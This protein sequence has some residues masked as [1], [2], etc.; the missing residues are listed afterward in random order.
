MFLFF[1]MKRTIILVLYILII[2][3]CALIGS[4]KPSRTAIRELFEANQLIVNPYYIPQDRQV[5]Q[6]CNLFSCEYDKPPQPAPLPLVIPTPPP[7]PKKEEVKTCPKEITLEDLNDYDLYTPQE[8]MV[9]ER[10]AEKQQQLNDGGS[11]ALA[12]R[13]N[14]GCK[15]SRGTIK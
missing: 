15:I 4:T 5:Q 2:L 7:Q 14:E 3:V 1:R 13:C 6:T 11:L 12:T 10:I 9:E 8:M